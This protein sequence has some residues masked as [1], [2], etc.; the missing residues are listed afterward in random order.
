MK[1]ILFSLL[2]GTALFTACKKD[3]N[4]NASAKDRITGQWM[5][6]AF[7]RTLFV[8]SQN[9]TVNRYDSLLSCERDDLYLFN[10][11]NTLKR[12]EGAQKCR[13]T[14]PQQQSLGNYIITN[15]DTRLIMPN[16]DNTS[17]MDTL[18][19]LELTGSTL[20]TQTVNN[21]STSGI[22]DSKTYVKK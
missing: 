8:G 1:K 14:D 2:A 20:R 16:P 11:D 13:S 12:D 10:A 4:N 9:S 21:G 6:T 3:D 17:Q 15:N 7:N 19:I 22:R 5:L 18:E